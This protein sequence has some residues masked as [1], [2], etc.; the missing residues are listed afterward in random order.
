MA[1]DFLKPNNTNSL[2]VI[3]ATLHHRISNIVLK[4]MTSR[5]KSSR[6]A[7]ITLLNCRFY[8]KRKCIHHRHQN[9]HGIPEAPQHDM[10]H[11][12]P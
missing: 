4:S 7:D 8:A 5:A 2:R 10:Q 1:N 6:A 11:S 12:H 9:I 3:M